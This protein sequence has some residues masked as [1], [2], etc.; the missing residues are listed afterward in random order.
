M[1]NLKPTSSKVLRVSEFFFDTIQGEGAHIGHPA[2]FLRL[3][4]CTLKCTYCD[5][6][7]VWRRGNAYKF[8]ELFT[9]MEKDMGDGCLIDK[10]KEGQ[11]LVITGG[12]PLLQQ[13]TLI[14]FI[15][16]FI[17]RYNFKPFIEVE[18][19]CMI[20]PFIGL[21]QYVD[22]W[23][24]S[25]KLTRSGNSSKH[26]PILIYDMAQLPNSWFKFA[27]K[28]EVD[29]YEINRDFIQN[30]LISKNQVILMP[31]GST[32]SELNLNLPHVLQISIKN[33]V[34]FSTRQHIAIWGVATGV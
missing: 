31:I 28:N 15:T 24:N 8:S 19:E 7:K 6:M 13:G 10:L 29:W 30:G 23:N 14:E 33:N 5:T 26:D 3:Q 4:G 22:C 32:I 18:N 2:A 12:S 11:H 17:S 21:V 1:V 34:K 27:I 25:P 16:T 9:L 20:V